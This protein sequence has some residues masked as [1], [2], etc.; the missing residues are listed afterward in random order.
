LFPVDAFLGRVT[1]DEAAI[2]AHYES[3]K[4]SYQTP[5]TVDLE[6]IE[7]SLADMA[8]NVDVSEDALKA[9]YEE[10]RERFQTAEE[11][12]ARHI[13][14]PIENGDEDA[15]RA[16]AEAV[17]ERLKKGEDFAK[18]AS[19]LSTDV[20]TKGQGGDLG[21]IS[22]GMLEGPFEDAL[23]A[24]QVGEVKGPVKTDFGYHVIRL[25]EIR[26]GTTQPFETVRDQLATE[27][28]TR[29]AEQKFYDRANDLQD[30]AFQA[31]NELA[32][33]ATD[34]QLPLK[35]V[36]D[37]PR[38]G[39][40]AVFGN[41]AA[42][43]QAAFT[44]QMLESGRNSGLV[45]LSEDHVIVLRVTA[46]HV[47]VTKPLDEVREQIRDELKRARAEELSEQASMAFATAVEKP[48]ADPAALAVAQS[49]TWKPPA[50]TE[51]TDPSVPTE[52]LATAFMQPK[53]AE[54]VVVRQQVPLANGSHAVL[55]LSGVKAGSPDSVS[56]AERDQRQRQLAEQSAY[57][58]LTS[59][60]G[61]LREQATV[62][63]PPE[64]LEPTT[65]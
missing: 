52:L 47:P 30:K 37:F 14:I 51:R 27:L 25:D 16:K 35:T 11:R 63:I 24:M 46:H 41:S 49:G 6:Y 53:P 4:V 10:E 29:G 57:A 34:L 15:A 39:D 38:T 56:Q 45:E 31:Y 20:G 5:E 40:P 64:I 54:G 1:V 62:R 48:G 42:V 50:W 61:T 21:W 60:V 18:L 23:F 58:E 9:A 36:K 17:V 8:A 33:V 28:K 59:Y 43:V 12:H 19:E 32:T 22:R 65:Y 2:A 3:N 13:L 26:P 55:V 44:D 7:L